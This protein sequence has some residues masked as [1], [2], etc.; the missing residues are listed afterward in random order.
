LN[1]F[2]DV[3]KFDPVRAEKFLDQFFVSEIEAFFDV[4]ADLNKEAFGAA[5]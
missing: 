3:L 5:L 1:Q 4:V 2:V